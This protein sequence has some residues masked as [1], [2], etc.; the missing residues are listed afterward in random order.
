MRRD[1]EVLYTTVSETEVHTAQ[2]KT[3]E[4]EQKAEAA[5]AAH[6][7]AE[8]EADQLRRDLQEEAAR[9]EAEVKALEDVIAQLEEEQLQHLQMLKISD[10]REKKQALKQLEA[11]QRRVAEAFRAYQSRK[12]AA[13]I[14]QNRLKELEKKLVKRLSF[15]LSWGYP[16]GKQDFLDATCMMIKKSN[17]EWEV[18]QHG[19]YNNKDAPGIR[20]SGDE[21]D[22]GQKRGTHTMSLT[23]AEIPAEVEWLLFSLSAFNCESIS[24]FVS[25]KLS[26]TNTD[27]GAEITSY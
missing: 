8:A 13:E 18:N 20:H 17:G 5:E 22:D 2:Q 23:M 24:K 6:R 12:K 7:K 25:P 26:L 15:H 19:D 3:A 10:E 11:M 14:A 9:R 16:S 1:F 4:A 21:M 27:S